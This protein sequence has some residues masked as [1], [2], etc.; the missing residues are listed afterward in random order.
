MKVNLFSLAILSLFFT[1]QACDKAEHYRRIH[2]HVLFQ[3]SF[4]LK[5]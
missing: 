3:N 2:S 1:F 5:L 4:L